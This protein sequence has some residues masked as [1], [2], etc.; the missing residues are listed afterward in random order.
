M[1]Q[2]YEG[3]GVGGHSAVGGYWVVVV[4]GSGVIGTAP[5]NGINAIV[6][7]LLWCTCLIVCSDSNRLEN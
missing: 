4:V 2:I 1:T 3:E 7:F 6:C 5:D